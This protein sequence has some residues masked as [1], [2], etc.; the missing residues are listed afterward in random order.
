MTIPRA[1][2]VA[3]LLGF[4]SMISLFAP[5]LRADEP[6]KPP[7]EPKA[8]P[9]HPSFGNIVRLDP[10]FDRLIPEKSKLQ[11][12]AEGFIW[13]EGPIWRRPIGPATEG[14][15]N[16][17]DIPRNRVMKWQDGK[18]S[19][20]LEPAGYLGKKPRGGESGTNGL[21]VDKVGRLVMCE[22]G[23]RRIARLESDGT[24]T[25]LVD[26]YEGKRF[27]S[28]NDLCFK[29]NGDLYFTDPAY[30]LEKGY[31][32]PGRE[33]DYCGVF[34]L[35]PDGKVDLLTKELKCPNGIAFSPDESVLYIS[36]S[37]PDRPV[38]MAYPMK[39]DGRLGTGK[40]FFDST[41]WVKENKPGLPDGMKI[42]ARGN[43][44]ATGPGGL[45]VFSSDGTHLGVVDTGQRTANCNWGDAGSTLYICAHMFLARIQT[46]TR[47]NG[48]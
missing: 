44:F 9:D 33:M 1:A 17:S 10:R 27:N 42:D 7:A 41:P 40:V 20:F 5:P 39:P 47:G 18:L 28:P 16:F 32:D 11:K 12:L 29:S 23:E 14:F 22:H 43:L 8:V 13:S 36:N 4:F 35:K 3:C 24:Q 26:H 45:H 19:V 38:W 34:R 25:S 37:D 46:N 30:G 15:L 31:D 6:A 21:T 2:L 48:W